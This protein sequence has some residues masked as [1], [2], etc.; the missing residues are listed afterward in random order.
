MP[1]VIIIEWK[2]IDG[3]LFVH[4]PEPFAMAPLEWKA[5]AA[6]FDRIGF[7]PGQ[8][9]MRT[10]PPSV[11]APRRLADGLMALGY[12]LEHRGDVPESII[13]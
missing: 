2:S 10:M 13:K 3:T 1:R 8:K 12:S 6:L 5:F 9:D 4:F 7:Q 11:D